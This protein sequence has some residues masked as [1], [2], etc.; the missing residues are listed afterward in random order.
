MT[1]G[2]MRQSG[3]RGLV[4]TCCACSHNTE[5]DVNAWPDDVSVRSFG[6][7]MRCTMCG[8]LGATAIPNWKERADTMPGG[9]RYRASAP[10]R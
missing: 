5:V 7:H 8:H 3:V 9:A 1:L 6:L 10:Y 4:A 2:N